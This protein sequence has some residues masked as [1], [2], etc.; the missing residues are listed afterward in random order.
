MLVAIL[1]DTHLPRA[2]RVFPDECVKRMESADLILHAGDFVDSIVLAEMEIL[3]PP[4]EA[5]HGN[6][7]SAELQRALPAELTL[8]LDG[9]KVSLLHDAGPAAGRLERMRKRF[10]ESAAV[11]FGHSHLPLHEE[12][13]GFHLFNP[14]SPTDKRREPRH[15]MGIARIEDGRIELEHVALD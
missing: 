4:V 3:G 1:A 10:P 8:D 13:D 5:V 11:I 7:D 9:V 14:G 12:R 15:T 6:L 2:G